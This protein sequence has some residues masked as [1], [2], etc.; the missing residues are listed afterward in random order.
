MKKLY[1][2][3]RIL[4]RWRC[5]LKSSKVSSE[6]IFNFNFNLKLK[7]KL[8]Y[9]GK[10]EFFKFFF[11]KTKSNRIFFF[12][13]GYPAVSL[14]FLLA[15]VFLKITLKTR[16]FSRFPFTFSEWSDCTQDGSNLARVP[17]REVDFP[18]SE[19]WKF[20]FYSVKKTKIMLEEH[21]NP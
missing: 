10:S 14:F 12:M 4:I 5:G 7:L 2:Q 11:R 8:I 9:Q 20:F 13:G 3:I 1:V 19:N 6:L 15:F 17:L 21:G 18:W 16:I